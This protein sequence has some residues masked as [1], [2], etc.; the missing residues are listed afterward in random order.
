MFSYIGKR[1]PLQDLIDYN[2]VI[3]LFGGKIC[4]SRLLCSFCLTVPKEQSVHKCDNVRFTDRFFKL[5]QIYV[6]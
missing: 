5:N 4:F 6:I 3:G 1:W 2:G